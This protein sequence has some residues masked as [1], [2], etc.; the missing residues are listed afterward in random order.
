MM[1]KIRSTKIV[2]FMTPGAGA[3]LLGCGH[4]SHIVKMH[5]IFK[6]LL[7]YTQTYSRQTES[8]VMM[9]KK[10]SIKIVNFMTHGAGVIVL[11]HGHIVKMQYFFSSFCLLWGMGLTN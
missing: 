11:G 5:Y 9:T 1:T 3:F 6:N 7:L 4:L 10:A 8:I 2:N